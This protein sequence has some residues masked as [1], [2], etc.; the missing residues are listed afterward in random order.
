MPISVCLGG[1]VLFVMA[2]VAIGAIQKQEINERFPPITDDEFLAR[3]SPGTNPEIAL[4]V[5][6]IVSELLAV[7]YD[8]IYPSTNFIEDLGAD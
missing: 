2:L 1:L 5:R 6:R 7:E 3:C 4:K 8:R